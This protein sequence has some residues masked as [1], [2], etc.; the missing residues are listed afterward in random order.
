M[1]GRDEESF[2]ALGTASGV[3]QALVRRGHLTSHA[4]APADGGL[5]RAGR[6]CRATGYGHRD[7]SD[8]SGPTHRPLTS[9]PGFP[10]EAGEG[11]GKR[12][13]GYSGP[14]LRH[15]PPT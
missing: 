15:G 14:P 9:G 3:G 8:R 6:R 12:M 4:G 2:A 13:G 5:A 1:G 7:P 11:A 10:L